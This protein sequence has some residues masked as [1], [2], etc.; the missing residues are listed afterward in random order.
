[1][2][3]AMTCRYCA[4][5]MDEEQEHYHLQVSRQRIIWP[6]AEGVGEPTIDFVGVVEVIADFCSENC[7]G[8]G[9][10]NFL[11]GLGA[12]PTW[13]DVRPVEACSACGEDIKTAMPHLAVE[14]L[15][16]IGPLMAGEIVDAQYPARFC[17]DCDPSRVQPYMQT[18]AGEIK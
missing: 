6:P 9:A 10:R 18:Y 15:C 12:K 5:A 2:S 4:A 8:M 16:E 11:A 3:E 14:M 13:S 1:M 17:R 7:A